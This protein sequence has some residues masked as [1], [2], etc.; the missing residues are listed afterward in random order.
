MTKKLLLILAFFTLGA[1]SFYVPPKSSP[2]A[3]CLYERKCNDF[4]KYLAENDQLTDQSR[5]E[6]YILRRNII[7]ELINRMGTDQNGQNGQNSFRNQLFGEI[8]SV[9]GNVYDKRI[10]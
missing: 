1:Q 10:G 2:A 7:Q 3:S 6:Y 8:R 5:Y 4:L 9:F